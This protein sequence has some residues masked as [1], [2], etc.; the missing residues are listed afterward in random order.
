MYKQGDGGRIIVTAGRLDS[1]NTMEINEQKTNA[2]KHETWPRNQI[3]E[4]ISTE[5]L[6]YLEK[7]TKVSK[8]IYYH[9][10]RN[11]TKTR[12]TPNAFS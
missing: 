1:E 9:R 4:Q 3:I 6:I 11:H 10:T 7:S 5:A 8:E 12:Q 2:H